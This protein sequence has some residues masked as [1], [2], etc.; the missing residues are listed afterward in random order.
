MRL[1]LTLLGP[2]LGSLLGLMTGCLAGYGIGA[3]YPRRY[4]AA[5]PEAPT[6]VL[7]LASRP[8]P[9]LAEVGALTAGAGG[10]SLAPYLLVCAIGNGFYALVVCANAALWVDGKWPL[11][12]LVLPL[13]V[14][15]LGWLAWRRR[16]PH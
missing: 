9:V 6:L 5:L 11:A 12:A 7:L 3:L 15:A 2:L 10:V 4:R 16:Y 13:L 14:P 1:R 8:V